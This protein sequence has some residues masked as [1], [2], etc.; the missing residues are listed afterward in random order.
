MKTL[1]LF[2][3][4]LIGFTSI[5]QEPDPDLYQTWYLYSYEYDLGDYILV[6]EIEPAISPNLII[7]ENLDFFGNGACNAY[8]GNFIY[9]ATAETLTPENF[10]QSLLNCDY[11]SHTD[12]ELDYF[13][14]FSPDVPFE[15]TIDTNP[16]NPNNQ[17]LILSPA[18]GFFLIY[19][20]TQLSVSENEITSFKIYPNP[21]S[22][23]LFISSE[24]NTI[25][26]ISVFSI[27]GQVVLSEKSNTNQLDVS[28]L[29]NG[30]YFVE[31]A[32]GNGTSIQKF[33]KK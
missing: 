16:N 10:V 5:S 4:L 26:N 12:F 32:S 3:A 29:S 1:L 14:F 13:G 25:E 17:T 24:N 19:S 22:E 18:P 6:T 30:L 27:N 33:I 11:Q 28:T 23:T 2:I 8:N 21:V 9:D 7:E 31:I 15:Y 20:N